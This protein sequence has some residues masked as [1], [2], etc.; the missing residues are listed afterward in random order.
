[1][2]KGQLAAVAQEVQKL[3]ILQHA[4]MWKFVAAA[5]YHPQGFPARAISVHHICY[6]K[7][8]T[9]S[10]NVHEKVPEA[11][12]QVQHKRTVEMMDVR[13]LPWLLRLATQ[14]DI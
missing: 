12:I 2:S 14:N 10:L 8:V 5:E 11:S 4:Q 1:M 13:L 3:G 9:A 6:V 7:A